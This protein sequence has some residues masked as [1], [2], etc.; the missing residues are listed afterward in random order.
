MDSVLAEAWHDEHCLQCNE[1][2]LKMFEIV[3]GRSHVVLGT[4]G[5]DG[6]TSSETARHF[7]E[8]FLRWC[9]GADLGF[10]FFDT[11]ELA[12][13]ALC[14]GDLDYLLMP[15]AYGKMTRFYWHPRIELV[16][17]FMNETP[18]YGIAVLGAPDS[19]ERRSYTM[20]TCK[21]VAH[22]AQEL[23]D[24]TVYRESPFQL[25]EE[26]S[27]KKS[28]MLMEQGV[29]DFA[30]TNDS[31]LRDSDAVFISQTRRAD[32][33]WSIFILKDPTTEGPRSA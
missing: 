9:P 1:R 20:A 28:L 33:L 27:T 31:S 4:L 19:G 2:K 11:F 6:T 18:R 32:V 8:Y 24:T 15:N 16:Y 10:E 12:L 14:S 25:V 21:P 3:R 17:S 29:A 23:W 30:L 5:P 13:A 7:R 26:P 22:L